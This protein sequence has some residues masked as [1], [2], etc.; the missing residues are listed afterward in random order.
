MGNCAVAQHAVTSW[1]D[2]GEWDVPS[3]AE[4]EA[5]GAA[6]T[7]GW[8][9]DKGRAA[10]EVTIRIPRR[11]LQE[12]MEKRAPAAGG[13]LRG[14]AS[15][16]AAAQAQLLLADVMN[17]GHVYLHRCRAAHWKPALQ[18]IPEAAVES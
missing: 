10:A 1:A 13:L 16:G 7:S 3:A 18:S 5:G 6:G 2:D 4:D 9:W 11:Q 14:L 8:E 15:R 17:A 12:L